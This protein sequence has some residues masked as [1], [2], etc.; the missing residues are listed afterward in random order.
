MTGARKEEQ[1]EI[2]LN[3]VTFLLYLKLTSEHVE[4]FNLQPSELSGCLGM[5]DLCLSQQDL[6]CS[7]WQA[8]RMGSNL[9][10]HSIMPSS[11]PILLLKKSCSSNDPYTSFD[12]SIHKWHPPMKNWP[13]KEN[14][15]L[16]LKGLLSCFLWKTSSRNKT[17]KT[18]F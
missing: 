13:P 5:E 17:G 14:T 4:W 18:N 3:M 16:L 1:L 15:A 12:E 2:V 11:L 7:N 6:G 10:Q 9:G 8:C